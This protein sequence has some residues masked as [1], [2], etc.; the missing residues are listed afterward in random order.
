MHA[1]LQYPAVQESP[2][3]HRRKISVSVDAGLDLLS[4]RP[5]PRIPSM[6]SDE[7]GDLQKDSIYEQPRWSIKK[8]P[9]LIHGT[10]EVTSPTPP[11][12]SPIYDTPPPGIRPA[13]V[14]KQGQFQTH[15]AWSKL[16]A[17]PS[18]DKDISKEEEEDPK[19]RIIMEDELGCSA[20]LRIPD[21]GSSDDYDGK[22]TH[23]MVQF[24]HHEHN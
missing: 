18:G 20:T 21:A 11:S 14:D 10:F 7:E 17:E 6:D 16:G 2:T 19:V 8:A 9:E 3:V 24:L 15:G 22:D 5:L 1:Y 23:A 13:A 12:E 4:K